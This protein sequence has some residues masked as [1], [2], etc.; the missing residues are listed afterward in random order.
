MQVRTIGT[1]CLCLVLCR[2]AQAA[3]GAV[4][5]GPIG[6]TDIRNAYLP[7]LPGF[8]L[9]VAN[10]PGF[11][12]IIVGNNGGGS[13]TSR[14]V[15][16][17]YDIQA[18]GLVYAYPFKLFG[19]SLASAAQGSYTPYLRFSIN[20]HTEDIDGW[21]DLYADVLKWSRLFG[22]LS[23]PR[24]GAT[25]LPYGLAVQAAYSMIF[26]IGTYNTHQF[27]TP[28][29]NDYFIIPN[30]AVTYLTPPNFLG[31]GLELSAHLFYDHAT[32]NPDDAYTTGDVL[33]LD[34]AVTERSGRWQ[35]GVAG[36]GA[37]QVASDV[38]NGSIVK[39]AGKYFDAA[40]IGPVV[41][42]DLPRFGMTFKVKVGAPLY[43]R[44]TIFGPQVVFAMGLKL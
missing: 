26:P 21:G 37:F 30:A 13:R 8:Y 33:D 24:P 36:F 1:I 11:A 16:L 14:R 42:Y 27:T 35:Y 34:Y 17:G 28:G 15:N 18:L 6:G 12:G 10:V 32:T 22:T 3:E 23:A 44:N 43:N 5:G 29:H 31:D 40:K 9:G 39:P 2:P 19:G 41:A 25:P 38:Q 20:N 4:Y 7:P